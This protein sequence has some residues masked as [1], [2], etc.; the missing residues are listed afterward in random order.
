MKNTLFQ[1]KNQNQS[2]ELLNKSTAFQSKTIDITIDTIHPS[3]F[4]IHIIFAIFLI[5]NLCELD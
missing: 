4:A 2:T 5:I 1:L 3:S